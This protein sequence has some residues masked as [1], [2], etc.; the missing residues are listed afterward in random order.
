MRSCVV[1]IVTWHLWCAIENILI[2]YFFRC[3]QIKIKCP[4]FIATLESP[5][6][7]LHMNEERKKLLRQFKRVCFFCESCQN[8]SPFLDFK[9]VDAEALKL[10]HNCNTVSCIKFEPPLN[11]QRNSAHCSCSCW[12]SICFSTS[13]EW[14]V[15]TVVL[16][17]YKIVD[18]WWSSICVFILSSHRQTNLWAVWFSTFFKMQNLNHVILNARESEWVRKM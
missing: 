5:F 4:N 14:S 12:N 17:G 15:F 3:L 1:K 9:R 8:H 13:F 16:F 6:K 18:W 11:I 10:H 7:R 2:L